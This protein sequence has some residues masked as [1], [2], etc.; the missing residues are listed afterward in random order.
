MRKLLLS[1]FFM[2]AALSCVIPVIPAYAI[3]LGASQIVSAIAAGIFALS[4]AIAMTPFGIFSEI[5]GRRI[6]ILSGILMSILASVLYLFS[7]TTFIL[8]AARFIHGLGVAMYIPAINALV[9]DVSAEGRRGESIGWIQTSLMFGFFVGPMLGGF[10]AE[11]WGVEK[12]FVLSLIFAL[13]S[14]F[15]ALL[16]VR[17]NGGRTSKI[18]LRFPIGMIPF[19]LLIFLGTATTSA[20]AIFAL[21]YYRAEIGITEFQSGVI[22]SALFLFSSVSRV[23]AGILADRAGRRTG[24]TAGIVVSSLGLFLASTTNPVRVFLAASVCGAGMGILNT[25]VF[26]AASDLENRGF[27]LGLANSFLNAGIFLGSTL[28]GFMAGFMSFG[29]MMLYLAFITVLLIPLAIAHKN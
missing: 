27:A 10:T 1:G 23:P 17:K 25:S 11:M 20:L 13:L 6:F 18:S 12:V 21:P 5:H 26:A 2:Y 29:E 19:Y 9:A 7:S 22:V 15:F 24:A 28:A 16:S 8:I 3:T 14:L 4:P